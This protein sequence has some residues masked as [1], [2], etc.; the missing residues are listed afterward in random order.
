MH[1][2][3]RVPIAIERYLL[4]GA[5]MALLVV[6]YAPL[7][8]HWVY[9]WLV[10]SS[11]SIQHEYFSH[12]LIGLPFA[13]Y[14]VWQQ[15]SRWQRLPDKTHP[16]GAV[17]LLG[18]IV[19]YL[20]HQ[21]DLMNL[22]FPFVLA[23]LCLWLKGLSGLRLQGFPLLLVLLATPNQLP[24]LI[25]PYILPLQR[26]ITGTAGFILQQMGVQVHVEQIYLFVN[27]N[28]ASPVEVAPHC[29]GLKMLFTSL[30]VGLMLLYWTGSIQ[31]RSKSALFLGGVVLVSVSANIV[32]NAALT[33]FHGTGQ[34]AAF[35]WLHE[36]WGGDVYS[37]LSLLV[38]VVL[39]RV[40]DRFMPDSPTPASRPTEP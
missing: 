40:L 36:S 4:D 7:L 8:I 6:L 37:A 5:I 28:F 13:A 35:H 19:A 17:L 30:Y 34:D 10:K 32:R 33:Y 9:G 31:S 12:G 16:L 24:Y 26:F 22:S 23:G 20:S 14:I 18:G 2:K 3:R 39:L 29:A 27:N 11:I 1:I 21:P 38:L 15:R 25:E